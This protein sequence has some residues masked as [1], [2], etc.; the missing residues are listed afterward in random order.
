M[1]ARPSSDRRSHESLGFL[2]T[3]W[4]AVGLV[5]LA[6]LTQAC[7]RL[8]R[9]EF[10]GD[11]GLPWGFVE[12]LSKNPRPVQS[13]SGDVALSGHTQ[14]PQEPHTPPRNDAN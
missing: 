13:D 10:V 2:E 1:F 5:E 12:S 4:G 3:F 8:N 6:H 7:G 11:G 9:S 14:T